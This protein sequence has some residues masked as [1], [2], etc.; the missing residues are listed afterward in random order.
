[1]DEE[2]E[3]PMAGDEIVERPSFNATRAVTIRARSEEIWPWIVQIGVTRAGWY[4]YDLLDNLGRPSARRILP[5]F[6]NPKA[7]DVIPM[8]P[9]GT[10]GPYVKDFEQNRWMLWW[11]QKGGM[12]WCWGLYP[13]AAALRLEITGDPLPHADR[14][15]RRSD[16][17]QEYAGHQG[18]G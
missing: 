12:S 18:A 16:D 1:T 7:G 13:G 9:D 14:I 5:Q 6:Q 8:S 3:R 15:H 4:S 2:V 11:D 17:A 10:Q